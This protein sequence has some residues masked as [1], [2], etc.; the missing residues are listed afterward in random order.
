MVELPDNF[1]SLIA[2]MHSGIGP[3]EAEDPFARDLMSG[4][5]LFPAHGNSSMNSPATWNSMP[6]SSISLMATW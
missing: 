6:W 4:S 5:T 3:Q 2:D 1:Y